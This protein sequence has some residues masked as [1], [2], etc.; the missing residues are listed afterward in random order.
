MNLKNTWMALFALV[1]CLNYASAQTEKY[2]L[3]ENIAY[4]NNPSDAYAK[5]RCKLDL[6]YPKDKGFATIVWFHGGGLTGGEKYIPE[7]LKNKGVAVAAVNYRLS[8]K[9]N[10]PA[11]IDDAAASVAWVFDHIE[12]FG[13]DPSKI[14]VSGHSAGGYLALMVGLD[15]QYL[16]KYNAD[17]NKVKAYFPISGQTITHNTVRKELGRPENV[18]FANEFA[19]LNHVK[20]D[21]PPFLLI[22]GDRTKEIPSR[23]MEN[24]YLYEA[25]KDVGNDKITLYEEDGFDHNSVVEPACSLIIK[26]IKDN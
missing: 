13:G 3:K 9:A 21:T 7:G 12:E 17:V 10:H 20:K 2:E 1:L 11:Y 14:Y 23:Y 26:A 18:P 15:E 16:Q 6:Y 19:P 24:A 25:L 4:R 8:P 22:T 5:S